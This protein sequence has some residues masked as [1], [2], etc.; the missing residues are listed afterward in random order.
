MKALAQ[1]LVATRREIRS[2]QWKRGDNEVLLER[3]SKRYQGCSLEIFN[4]EQM[5]TLGSSLGSYRESSWRVGV[6]RDRR[7]L[8]SR[9]VG[10]AYA[11]THVRF[12]L[13]QK[14]A[15]QFDISETQNS[16]GSTPKGGGR[17]GGKEHVR[18]AVIS[19][20]GK[21]L[22]CACGELVVGPEVNPPPPPEQAQNKRQT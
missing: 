21:P 22:S 5:E 18:V 16:T 7:A 6:G 4:K 17:R 14:P 8:S 19:P 2:R 13:R 11:R 20:R 9:G 1:A 10:R 3:R 12:G 15:T